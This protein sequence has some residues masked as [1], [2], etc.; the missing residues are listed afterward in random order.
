ME[1]HYNPRVDLDLPDIP[2]GAL[3]TITN[4]TVL[5][6]TRSTIDAARE[7]AVKRTERAIERIN[8]VIHLQWF[9]YTVA[10][11]YD[12]FFITRWVGYFSYGQAMA[13][14]HADI[15]SAKTTLR[16]EID[17]AIALAHRMQADPA[18]YA[19]EITQLDRPRITGP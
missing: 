16:R 17:D 12:R 3:D 10:P 1:F 8:C 9:K 2:P 4:T 15:A 11:G 5:I 14:E 19:H 7:R 18:S 13:N 6:K